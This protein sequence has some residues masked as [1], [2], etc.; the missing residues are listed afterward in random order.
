MTQSLMDHVIAPGALTT[1]FQP[2]FDIA[3]EPP[4][5]AGFECLTRGP[6]G[7]TLETPDVLFA[8]ARRRHEEAI[9]DRAAIATALEAALFVP[10]DIRLHFN[11]HASTLGRDSH[12]PRFLESSSRRAGVPLAGLTIEVLEHSDFIDESVYLET[13]EEL[14]RMGVEIALDDLGVGRTNFRLIL[15]TKPTVIKV[16]RYLVQRVDEDPYRQVLLSS[17]LSLADRLG[18]RLVAEGVEREEEL[19]LLRGVG[20]QQAQGFLLGRPAPLAS[21]LGD[22][23][24]PWLAHLPPQS[25][26]APSLAAGG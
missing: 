8:Y 6:K 3:S 10:D 25:A 13:L 23:M 5:I 17:L 22:D 2:I 11:V 19:A 20:F 7:T 18:M 15:L 24:H 9:V 12:F 14:R 4:R 21:W 16:D 26:L 1:V